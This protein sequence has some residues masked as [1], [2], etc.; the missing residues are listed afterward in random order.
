MQCAKLHT[1]VRVSGHRRHIQEAAAALQD[2]TAS[3]QLL[4]RRPR[5]PP[6]PKL[7]TTI[8]LVCNM[9][10]NICMHHCMAAACTFWSLCV[11]STK[12][13]LL[14]VT[15]IPPNTCAHPAADALNV[16][17]VLNKQDYAHLHGHEFHL[18]SHNIDPTVKVCRR[19][20]D[21]SN[22]DCVC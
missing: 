21:A 5:A 19:S 8:A 18:S 10:R 12:V 3:R 13:L 4:V 9:L 2:G 7:P 11:V 1:A 6:P 22:S 16:W 17:S 15:A 20:N 14:Q